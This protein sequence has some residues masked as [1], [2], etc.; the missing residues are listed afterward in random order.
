M[1]DP[2]SCCHRQD[3]CPHKDRHERRESIDLRFIATFLRFLWGHTLLWIA[4]TLPS[5]SHLYRGVGR[6]LEVHP[7]GFG[8]DL[9]GLHGRA[10]CIT[11]VK[12]RPQ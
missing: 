6:G 7:V 10:V 8:S 12:A 1:Y 9:R 2:A 3:L 11:A 5:T 4:H